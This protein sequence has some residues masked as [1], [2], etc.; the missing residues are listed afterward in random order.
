MT[1]YAQWE[2]RAAQYTINWDSNGGNELSGDYTHGTVDYGTTIVKPIDPTKES[3]DEF[4]YAF[5]GWTTTQA[6]TGEYVTDFGEVTCDVTYYA[7]GRV[8]DETHGLYWP[9]V[10]VKRGTVIAKADEADTNPPSGTSAEEG[11]RQGSY[12][13][14]G[15]LSNVQTGGIFIAQGY[16]QALFKAIDAGYTYTIKASRSY[17]DDSYI[18]SYGE[19]YVPGDYDKYLCI[20]AF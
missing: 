3:T 19:D 10:I 12:G 14:T 18:D 9:N 6:D 7:Q 15:G 20:K 17:Y 1:Y 16:T 4:T 8:A 5:K 11:L 13:F 2:A